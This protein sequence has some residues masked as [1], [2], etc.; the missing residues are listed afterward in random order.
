[1]AG[2]SPMDRHL[3]QIDVWRGNDFIAESNRIEGINRPGTREEIRA[4]DHLWSL[5][6]ISVGDLE[7]FVKAIAGASL[8]R[9]PGRDVRVGSH[10]PPP[11]GPNIETQLFGLLDAIGSGHL[12]PFHAHQRYEHL[13]PFMDG[14][15]R[16]GRALWAWH[17]AKRGLD[18]FPLPFLHRWYYQSLEAGIS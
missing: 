5:E 18:P 1:M 15:G 14:N 16:S 3:W 11:G 9:Y 17:M 7:D 10:T 4:H 8:R 13:H 2:D 12:N 6:I